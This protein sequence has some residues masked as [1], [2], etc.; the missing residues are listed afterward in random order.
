MPIKLKIKTKLDSYPI[1]IGS[2]LIRNL[3]TY[4]KKNSIFFNQ[5]ILVIDKNV[6]NKMISKITNSLNK[7]KFVNLYLMPMKKIKI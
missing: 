2:N 3:D 7:K 1:I 6:P 4:L 5:C